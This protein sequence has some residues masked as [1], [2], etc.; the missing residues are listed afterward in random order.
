M[1]SD[2]E[3]P[4]DART[5]T[6]FVKMGSTINPD[7]QLTGDCPSLNHSGMMPALNTHLYV[8]SGKVMFQ[9]Y[10]KPMANPLMMMKNSAM[11]EKVKRTTLTQEGIRIMRNTSLELPWEVNAD[12]LSNLSMRMKASGYD[13]KM[14]LEVIKSAVTG[15][16][17]MV[18]VEKAGGRPINR[19]RDWEEDQRQTSKQTN[20]QNWYRKGGH[21]VPIFVPHTP[22]GEL[23]S[24][25]R[26]KEEENNQ[27][28][29]I[30]YLI[31]ERG[32][33]KIHNK[34][35]K[36]NP[37]TQKKCGQNDCFPCMGDRGGNCRKPGVTYKLT[38]ITCKEEMNTTMDVAKY[39]GEA[40]RN[41]HERGKEHWSG[42]LKK[43]EDSVLWLHS[44]YHHQ[45]STEVKYSMEVTGVYSEPLDRQLA[46]K[47]QISRFKGEILM[48][49]KNELGGALVPRERFKYRRWGAGVPN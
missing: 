24:R 41:A 4:A 11:P 3:I 46:E 39:A 33:T 44:V 25:M 12:H 31:C 17:K 16:E 27:G 34:L 36:A 43:S 2:L 18:E 47:I 35:W 45:A 5:M 6:E 19:P 32:G 13:E 30:R 10:R 40:G 21:H 38:C 8:N 26:R 22:G 7:I 15:F 48:N 29:K 28:R 37:W 20:K 23:A 14:R 1:Q 42:W 49:R 9:N